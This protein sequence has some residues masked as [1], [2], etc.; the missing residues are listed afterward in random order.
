[1]AGGYSSVF[2]SAMTSNWL[3]QSLDNHRGQ[4]MAGVEQDD[5]EARI[6]RSIDAYH[7]AA[8]LFT[9]VTARIPDLLN[10]GGRTPEMLASE[11]NLRPEPL[12]RFLRGLAT[13]QLCEELEDGRF[14]L[15]PAGKLLAI[16]SPSSLRQ[17]AQVVVGQYWLPWLSLMHCLET[18]EPSFPFVF[19]STISEWRA[20]NKNGGDPFYR[21]LA[22][23]D[24][25]VAN[26]DDLMQSFYTF[27]A[28]V[29]ASI[30]SGYGGFL[31]PFLHGFPELKAIVF[32]LES[33]V[34]GAESMFQDLGLQDQVSFVAG[35][36]LKAIPVEADI[37]FVNGVLQ[38]YGDTEARIIV[39]N[40]RNAMKPS[41]KLIVYERLMP[42]KVMD[43]P[44]AIMLDLHM[45]TITGGRVRTK[46][47]IE[48]LLTSAGLSVTNVQRTYG[49]LAFIEAVPV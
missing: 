35:D 36:I 44:D 12:R 29:I 26:A 34:E 13:M 1:M 2:E 14:V 33:T 49:G 30:G 31:V 48:E 15:T 28:D 47:E 46:A 9:A 24:M 42:E 3:M 7:E 11:L 19:G 16:G 8:L 38:R 18:G 5:L 43:D 17:K 23:E 27:E 6:R 21:Y 10:L 32:D 37:Y 20:A 4:R 22:K 45:M 40:C 25:S 39:E 41:A